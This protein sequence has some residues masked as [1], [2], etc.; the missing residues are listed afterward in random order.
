MNNINCERDLAQILCEA[1]GEKGLDVIQVVRRPNN[2][3]TTNRLPPRSAIETYV[4]AIW[5]ENDSQQSHPLYDLGVMRNKAQRSH[6][7]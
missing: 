6:H 7:E 2:N 5:R 1:I 4:L 3:N